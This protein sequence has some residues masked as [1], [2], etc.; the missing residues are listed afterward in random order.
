[1]STNYGVLGHSSLHFCLHSCVPFSLV[2]NE[3]PYKAQVKQSYDNLDVS[4]VS[5]CGGNE[6]NEY[7][8]CDRLRSSGTNQA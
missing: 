1:M 2:R 4:W 7:T 6:Y 3:A 8:L 5:I